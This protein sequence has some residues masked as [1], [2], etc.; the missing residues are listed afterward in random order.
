MLPGAAAAREELEPRGPGH[1]LAARCPSRTGASESTRPCGRSA[2]VAAARGR[3]ARPQGP[4]SAARRTFSP[5][6]AGARRERPPSR[7]AD[8]VPARPYRPPRLEAGRGLANGA[9]TTALDRN[10]CGNRPAVSKAELSSR[11][12]ARATSTPRTCASASWLFEHFRAVA[13]A[14]RLRGGRRA[15][16][17]ARG[18]VHAQGGRGD[19]RAA[20]PLRAARAARYALRPE[21]TPSLAR[22]VMARAGSLR[23]PLRWFAIAQCWR[24]ERMTRGRRREH[25]QWNMDIWGEPGVAAEAELIAARVRAARPRSGSRRGD[26]ADARHQPRAARGDAARGSTARPRRGLPG[27]LHRDRQARQDRDRRGGASSSPTRPA[28]IG[29]RA[30][31]APRWCDW[32]A[33][34]DRRRRP[35]R[36]PPRLA[37]AAPT[38]CACSSCSTPTALADR[39]EFDASI[40]R[41]LAYYTGIVFEAFDAGAQA[42]RDLRRRPLRPAC[43]RAL[44]GPAAARGGLRLRRRRDRGAARRRGRAAR[45]AARGSTRS[46]SR[47]ARRER[48]AAIRLAQR[49]RAGGASVELVLGAVKLK[50]ALADADRAGARAHLSARARGARARRRAGARPRQR[51]AERASRCR[52]AERSVERELPMR[53]ARS[54]CLYNASAIRSGSVADARLDASATASSSTTSR[55][56]GAGFFTVNDAGPRRGAAARAR[57]QRRHR[58][59]RAACA[60][61]SSAACARRC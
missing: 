8:R 33:A 52:P 4:A 9:R 58:P 38:C 43:S 21:F 32:L 25:Y 3:R 2:G 22:M 59:A 47:S 6:A 51:R 60:T 56:W 50:R 14:L 1:G 48:P 44:G 57:R 37:R 49:L 15:R 11:R 54:F 55:S 27:A 40:V 31:A 41:G 16:A 29:S 26:G 30:A 19:R 20:L 36:L 23:L 34:R 18:A 17:R 42:A 10:A 35:P 39:V 46:S 7:R 13:R 61:S 53:G 28:P 12:A 5:A 45:A 24:Y